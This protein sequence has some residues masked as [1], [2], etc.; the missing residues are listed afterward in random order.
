[1]MA[2]TAMI[3]T[4]SFGPNCHTSTGTNMIDEPVPMMPLT[5]PAMSPTVR[6]KMNSKVCPSPLV[7]AKAGPS[8]W[9]WMPLAR[10]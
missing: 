5:A 6:T 3:G 7:P 2:A 10:A 9:L 8:S 4:A 1:M